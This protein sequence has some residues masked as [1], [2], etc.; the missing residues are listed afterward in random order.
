MKAESI[1]RQPGVYGSPEAKI[2][3][4][5]IRNN[6]SE[7]SKV[8]QRSLKEKLSHIFSKNKGLSKP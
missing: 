8:D 5:S 3:I 2:M 4:K 1:I 7:Y 6:N